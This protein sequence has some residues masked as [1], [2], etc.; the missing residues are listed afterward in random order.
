MIS[1]SL[2]LAGG[3]E[4]SVH[5]SHEIDR[6]SVRRWWGRLFDDD[7]PVPGLGAKLFEREWGGVSEFVLE[8]SN[9]VEP[10]GNV[11]FRRLRIG[12]NGHTDAPGPF[13]AFLDEGKHR[14]PLGEAF[15]ARFAAYGTDERRRATIED[16]DGVVRERKLRGREALPS[17]YLRHDRMIYDAG[18]QTLRATYDADA[19]VVLAYDEETASPAFR[20]IAKA[21]AED[22]DDPHAIETS[23]ALEA[24]PEEPR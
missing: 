5:W 17:G 10:L 8:L 7:G 13:G 11:D 19:G 9:R 4:L 20:S 18:A 14:L 2:V 6:R 16:L 15:I 21:V 23:L 22:Q 1:A 3:R 12:L 24:K